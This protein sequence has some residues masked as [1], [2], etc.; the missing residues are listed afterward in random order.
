MLVSIVQLALVLPGGTL[1]WAVLGVALVLQ[2][3]LGRATPSRAGVPAYLLVVLTPLLL[4]GS[5]TPGCDVVGNLCD[6]S[7]IWHHRDFPP[8]EI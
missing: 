8:L 6:L 5:Y 4:W 2:Q 3:V 7:L 1:S